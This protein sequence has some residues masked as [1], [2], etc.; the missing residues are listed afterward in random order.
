[1]GE[2]AKELNNVSSGNLS[3]DIEY[4]DVTNLSTLVKGS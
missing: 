3:L 4:E 2:L 1:M